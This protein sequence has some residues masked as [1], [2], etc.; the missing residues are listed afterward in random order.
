[1]PHLMPAPG[2]VREAADARHP[3]ATTLPDAARLRLMANAI[4][5]LSMDAI[6]H[7]QSGHPGLPLGMAD[8]AATLFGRFIKVDSRAPHW[9]DRDR[10]V[11]SAG[12]G[13]MLLYALLHLMGHADMTIEALQR[14]RKLGSPAAG[15]PEY[16]HATGIE[17]TTGP[18]GQGLATA[19]GMAMA[20]RIQAARFGEALAD[21][22]TWVLASDGDLM[23][24]VSQESIGLAGRLGLGR[25]IV[26]FDDNDIS[27]DGKISLVDA[28]DQIARFQA[29]GWHTI[30]VDGHDP[31]AISD[32]IAQAIADPRPSLV[33]CRTVIGYGAPVKQGT[34]AAHSS[35]LGTQEVEGVRA[36]LGWTAGP[37]EIPT[38]ARVAWDAA[39]ARARAPH[40]AWQQ[41]LAASAQRAAFEA[42][43]AGGRPAGL[44]AAILA[45]KQRFAEKMPKLATRKASEAV[46]ELLMPAVPELV[47][48]SADLTSAN[49]TKIEGFGPIAEKNFA[50]RYVY[51]GIR[52]HAMA[53]AMNGMALHGGAI[54]ASG[55]FLAFSDYCRP[56]LRLAALMGVGAIHVMTHDSIGLGEDGPTHQPVEH[57]AALRAIPNLLLLRPAD[58]IETAE[59]WQIAMAERERPSVLALCRQEV[60]ALRRHAEAENFSS[61][62]AYE[63]AAADCEAAATL[64][65]SGSE[66][67]IAL[68]AREQLQAAGVPTRV[69]SVP[70]FELF[71][72]QGDDYVESVIGTAPVKVAVEA[73]IRQGWDAIIGRRG[74]FVGM[75]GFG[76]SAAPAELYEHFGITPAA[77]VTT[78]QAA[79]KK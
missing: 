67:S 47:T 62:G 56:A 4:R 15:H 14:F 48:G 12:H 37:F 30:R 32:A 40:A 42:S 19:I 76:A 71:F 24:G 45:I 63:I 29:S 9:P 74:G 41:R 18:L 21:H 33:A 6:E 5:A 53:A 68:A 72:E 75:K 43:L 61:R 73:A 79:L 28:T 65:A 52:E 8:V 69:V 34:P 58:P 66:V 11:L 77:V 60:P 7:A 51:W 1:M 25:L 49:F 31:E 35:P 38:E 20:E 13:S 46:L 39:A 59:C 78:V 55:T 17:T 36:H 10:F 2:A 44:D 22:R 23:E 70:C 64:F 27:I 26:L 3:A 57:L 50:G 16:G 54:P